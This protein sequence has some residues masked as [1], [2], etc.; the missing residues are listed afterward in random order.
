MDVKGRLIRN[1]SIPATG[2]KTIMWDGRSEQG[3][4]VRSGRYILNIRSGKSEKAV[5]FTLQK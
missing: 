2:R 4:L 1:L 3:K 5:S